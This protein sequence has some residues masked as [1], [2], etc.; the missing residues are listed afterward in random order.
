MLSRFVCAT[1]RSSVFPGLIALPFSRSAPRVIG[2]LFSSD[3]SY[4]TTTPAAVV[5]PAAPSA[6]AAAAVTPVDAAVAALPETHIDNFDISGPI[7][8]ALRQNFKI[9]TLFP[10]QAE[11][12]KPILEGQDL[13]GRS[14]TG[15]GKTL[16][17]VLPVVQ[18]LK[19]FAP[20]A[21]PRSSGGRY[22][23]VTD[24]K[25]RVLILEPTRE[26][27]NQVN[28]EILKLA[29]VR[30]AVLYGG[31]SSSE[32][33]R[34][35]GRG[36]DLVV[37]TPGRLLDM[38]QRG[39]LSLSEVKTVVLDE[40][41]EML[42]MGFQEQVEQ[43]MSHMTQ[44]KQ[45]LL[46][47]ATLPAWVNKTASRY[48]KNPILV[49]KVTGVV[50]TTPSTITHKA[51]TVTRHLPDTV[52]LLRDIFE[53][54]NV[55][56]VIVFSRTKRDC[57]GISDLL[58]N[59]GVR[60]R[61]LHGDVPQNARD[62][63]M[64]DFRSGRFQALV[65]TDVAARGLDVANVD[66][67]V[68]IGFP[69]DHAFYVHRSGRT[70]RAGKK[71]VSLLMHHQEERS[72]IHE[73]TKETGAKFHQFV[74]PDEHK[75]KKYVRR[76]LLTGKLGFTTIEVRGRRVNPMALET[77]LRDLTGN[78]NLAV[79]RVESSGETSFAD[80]PNEAAHVLATALEAAPSA[81]LRIAQELP[82][83]MFG[84]QRVQWGAGRSRGG[85]GGGRG[86]RG[87]GGG[88]GRPSY[89]GDRDGQ[90]S[91]YGR[92]RPSSYGGGGDRS[93][94]YGGD[95]SSRGGSSRDGGSN[96]GNRD[97]QY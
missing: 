31:A 21:T 19:Q 26:L 67:V 94:S 24:A 90:S 4:A 2:R 49:D 96:Y 87:G 40:A 41:D 74:M 75:G 35:L 23:Y 62:R 52:D 58:C 85:G 54:H 27:A 76:S 9:E 3:I 92:D 57:A 36:V 51:I 5:T 55:A 66:M 39:V 42:R 97:R 46:F 28:M 56:R 20:L 50:N 25:C 17:F 7:K 44:P 70:G 8:A 1:V 47:S 15:S 43:I 69:D 33:S 88:G 18:R 68:N 53:S 37:A 30:T 45:V 61:E 14:K 10:I 91:S 11:C 83:E 72:K 59:N 80:I 34:A 16:A 81:S 79:G 93:S 60:A 84:G 95:R 12:Y 22:G 89:G 63:T 32:Q 38:V 48:L 13:I 77:Q 86:G 65:A 29:H 64:S 73:L 82:E 6:A 78:E 71:G